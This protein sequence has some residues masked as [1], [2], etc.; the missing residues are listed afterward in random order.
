MAGKAEL[1]PK[2]Q[3]FVEEYLADCNGTQAAIRAGYSAR[4]AQEQASRLLSKVMVQEAIAAGRKKLSTAAEASAERVLREYLAL[5]FSD[6]GQILDFTGT[7]PHLRPAKDVPEAA[8]RAIQSV[9]VKRYTE[10]HGDDAREVEVTEFRL[11]S[12][13]DALEKLARHLGLL[14][15]QHEHSGTVRVE[16]SL[17]DVLKARQRAEEYRRGRGLARPDQG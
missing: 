16:V 4:T 9:K 11:W 14:K 13:T 6:V 15:D 17:E 1:T 3:R 5:A 12:K 8:R 7:D 10:G 2:Q